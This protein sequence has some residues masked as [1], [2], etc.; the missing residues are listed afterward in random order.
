MKALDG[1]IE[2]TTVKES[3]PVFR[4]DE[5]YANLQVGDKVANAGYLS[6]SASAEVAERH[7]AGSA[8]ARIDLQPGDHAAPTL[9]NLNNEFGSAAPKEKE[10]LLSR[11]TTLEVTDRVETPNGPRLTM[12]IA[13]VSKRCV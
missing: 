13:G 4:G 1:L 12:R 8:V 6:T 9:G 3:F 10:L 2:R 5:S 11:G 7:A